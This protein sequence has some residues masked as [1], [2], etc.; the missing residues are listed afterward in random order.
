MLFIMDGVK[1]SAGDSNTD[2]V[3]LAHLEADLKDN[4]RW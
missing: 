4:F 3:P 1:P 2:R